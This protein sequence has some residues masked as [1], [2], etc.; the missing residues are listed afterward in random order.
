MSICH[1]NYRR[2]ASVALVL[3]I[4]L[5]ALPALLSAQTAPKATTSSDSG[6][7]TLELFVGY[8]WYNPGGNVP[9]Q[10]VPPNPFKLP[11]IAPG[12]GTSLKE[13]H[14]EFCPG[15]RLRGGLEQVRDGQHGD[16]RSE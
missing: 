16:V 10:S 4:V 14:Q 1:E 3:A 13:L 7:P 15:R 9:D 6:V 11:S 5:V 12:V 2:G 8:Q